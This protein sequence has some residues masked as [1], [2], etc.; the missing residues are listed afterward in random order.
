M[1]T[2][3]QLAFVTED[4]RSS[5]RAD[6]LRE[7]ADRLDD[8]LLSDGAD[9]YAS[10]VNAPTRAQ[11]LHGDANQRNVLQS[12]RGWLAIDPRPMVGDPCADLATWV[13]TRLDEASSPVSRVADLADRLELPRPRALTWAAAQTLLLCSWLQDSG[14]AGP[15]DTYRNAARALM[16]ASS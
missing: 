16:T 4:A 8:A 12:E 5:R 13:T 6:Q 1:D 10:L 9:L 15:L 3:P 11:V 2:Q 14:E 7:R